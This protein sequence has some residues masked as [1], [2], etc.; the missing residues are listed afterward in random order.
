MLVEAGIEG[1]VGCGWKAWLGK[2][3]AAWLCPPANL[4][5][6]VVHY[7]IHLGRKTRSICCCVRH[8]GLLCRLPRSGSILWF[9]AYNIGFPNRKLV[10]ARFFLVLIG[11]VT[12]LDLS[13]DSCSCP[14]LAG[15]GQRLLILSSDSFLFGH[16]GVREGVKCMRAV[17]QLATLPAT[18]VGIFLLP[19]DCRCICGADCELLLEVL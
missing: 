1:K 18:L 6:W 14:Y 17:G 15:T 16:K 8:L 19:W 13:L 3:C 11:A 12:F 7:L 5:G 2:N 9:L 4:Q 10:K